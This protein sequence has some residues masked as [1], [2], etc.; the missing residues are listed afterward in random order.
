MPGAKF[1]LTNADLGCHAGTELAHNIVQT[2]LSEHI[3]YPD[4]LDVARFER[5]CTCNCESL[6][7]YFAGFMLLHVKFAG[8]KMTWCCEIKCEIVCW[9][10][11]L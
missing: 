2:H 7:V 9:I 8:F 11:V 5:T 1:V 6:S 10:H 3:A 4:A